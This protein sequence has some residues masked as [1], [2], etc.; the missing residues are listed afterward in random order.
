MWR[1]I[2]LLI[3]HELVLTIDGLSVLPRLPIKILEYISNKRLMLRYLHP[4]TRAGRLWHRGQ[5]SI[6]MEW[7]SYWRWKSKPGTWKCWEWCTSWKNCVW[8]PWH[9]SSNFGTRTWMRTGNCWSIFCADSSNSNGLSW[10]RFEP[11]HQEHTSANTW[12]P[13]DNIYPNSI[14][15]PQLNT[16]WLPGSPSILDLDSISS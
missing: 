13:F 14:F 12:H 15:D 6:L 5:K 2:V 1:M 10:G 16:C 11:L 9:W 3:L 8:N 7:Y 4:W